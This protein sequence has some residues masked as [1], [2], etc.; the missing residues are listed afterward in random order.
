MSSSFDSL[1]AGGAGRAV[2]RARRGVARGLSL[3]ELMVGI[4]IGL[5]IVAAA[6]VLVAGQLGEN[7][8]LMLDTQLQQDLRATAD[9]ITRELRRVNADRFPELLVAHPT[10][11][12]KVNAFTNPL[13]MT[14][15]ASG[16][17]TAVAFGYQRDTEFGPWGFQFDAAAGVI[18]TQLGA[19]G[20]QD[21]TDRNVMNVTAFS[22]Q[23][24]REPAQVLPC[25][26]LCA[27]NDTSCW[28]ALQVLNYRLEITAQSRADPTITRRIRSVVRPRNDWVEFRNA[29]AV[30][31]N[32]Q[33][34]P[35]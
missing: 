15:S 31:N 32:R 28:P 19:V 18:R 27:T 20:W 22:I 2:A 24:E 7:R 35:N 9:I 30:F 33:A 6:T 34:C 13:F 10:V 16:V 26:R 17:H 12:A 14:P 1:R 5:F 8:R 4:A 11:P 25:P 3:V 29:A 21:L 23:I